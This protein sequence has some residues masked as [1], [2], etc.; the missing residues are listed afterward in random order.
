MRLQRVR[1]RYV[2]VAVALSSLMIGCARDSTGPGS[3]LSPGARL[4]FV[5]QP[6]FVTMGTTI[7]PSVRVAVQDSLG[8]TIATDSSRVAVALVPKGN[9]ATLSGTT[10]QRASSGIATFNDL[11]VNVADSNYQ[12]VA[13]VTAGPTATSVRFSVIPALKMISSIYSAC[14]LTAG[15]SAYCASNPFFERTP[16]DSDVIPSL[17]PGL[18]FSSVVGSGGTNCGVTSSGA[19]YCWGSGSGGVLG[20]G[21][22]LDSA[23]PVPVSGGLT[24]ST[25]S[26]WGYT[27]CGLTTAGTAYC[28]GLFAL[29]NGTTQPS[30]VPTA[31]G[32]G[33]TFS[34]LSVGY[35]FV[36]GITKANAAYCWGDPRMGELGGPTTAANDYGLLPVA[37]SGGLSFASVSAG[38]AQACGVAT[39]GKAYCWGTNQAGQLGTT[40]TDSVCN[41]TVP[42]SDVP[43]AVTG[44]FT[45]TA[46]GAGE[47]ASC[48]LTTAGAVYCWGNDKTSP[49][50]I[51]G[52]P[53]LVSLSVGGVEACGL[54]AD[55]VG[56]CWDPYTTSDVARIRLY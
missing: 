28:W 41:G 42:C 2:I 24:L 46:V 11:S 50:Q 40:A 3:N 18:T 23:T 9:G 15:G 39:D 12:L 45:F 8:A 47:D 27:T 16:A 31:V 34:S 20:N 35:N 10:V 1:S 44:G 51:T 37:V 52:L 43:V 25:V 19:A 36:C 38:W 53:P 5:V 54:T 4:A 26:Q 49:W 14:A 55:G 29:G 21:D 48:G 13:S 22:T 17:V 7:A 30:N 56:Y 32:G 33:L 6:T